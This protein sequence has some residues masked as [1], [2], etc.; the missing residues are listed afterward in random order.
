MKQREKTD[1]PRRTCVLL[2]GLSL[3]LALPALLWKAVFCFPG[4]V[5][6][7]VCLGRLSRM[8][9]PGPGERGLDRCAKALAAAGGLICLLVAMAFTMQ[10]T[11]RSG[12]HLF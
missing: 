11:G 12:I 2:G 7:A 9:K 4:L 8:D 10:L 1:G 5:L 3:A 6:A